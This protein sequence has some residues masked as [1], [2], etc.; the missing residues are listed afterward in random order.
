[1]NESDERI[2]NL[3]EQILRWTKIGAVQLKST[4][5]EALQT[6]EAKL[7]Y[8]YSDGEKSSRDVS[9]LTNVSH[10][11]VQNYWRKWAT[12]GVVEAVEKYK[13]GRFK[14]LCSLQELGIAL[15]S[16]KSQSLI[17][18]DTEQEGETKLSP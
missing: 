13:G 11:T 12:L 17:E 7:V 1:M 18:E 16:L 9:K 4:L 6:D 2:I 3:L 15:P 14:R 8:E 10:A 5:R